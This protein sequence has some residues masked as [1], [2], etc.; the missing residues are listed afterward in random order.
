MQNWLLRPKV[1]WAVM[2]TMVLIGNGKCKDIQKR[3]DGKRE[4]DT[5]Q[6]ATDNNRISVEEGLFARKI[7]EAG[8]IHHYDRINIIVRIP[9]FI[10]TDE[11][12]M[13]LAD[14]MMAGS[15]MSDAFEGLKRQKEKFVAERVGVLKEYSMETEPTKGQKVK[16][17]KRKRSV[18]S[19]LGIIGGVAYSTFLGGL[20]EIQIRKLNTHLAET[21][22]EIKMIANK[23]NDLKKSQVIFEEKTVGVIKEVTESWLTMYDYMQCTTSLALAVLN[24][25]INFITYK[26]IVDNLLFPA[27]SGRNQVLLT[28]KILDITTLHQVVTKHPIFEN[29]EFGANPALLYSTSY[30]SLVGVNDQLTVA[31]L[32]LEF[33]VLKRN[34]YYPLFELK[35]V[36]LHIRDNQCTYFDIPENVIMM[37]EELR[38][39]DLQTCNRHNKL[40]LCPDHVLSYLPS[41]YQQTNYTCHQEQR[42]CDQSLEYVRT[43]TGVL[44]RTN[45]KEEVYYKDMEMKIRAIKTSR[46]DTAYI[47]WSKAE[48]VQ[49][50]NTTLF[51]PGVEVEEILITNYQTKLNFSETDLTMGEIAGTLNAVAKKYGTN[52]TELLK[53]SLSSKAGEKEVTIKG[54]LRTLYILVGLLYVAPIVML[55]K[56][57][58]TVSGRK[59]GGWGRYTRAN[60]NY[61]APR[62]VE[63]VTQG[64]GMIDNVLYDTISHSEIGARRCLSVT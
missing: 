24:G 1:L 64:P 27:L 29:S 8:I 30:L 26:S 3:Y 45:S 41:C 19:W 16:V 49:V 18:L 37:S 44:F 4:I 35:Q 15:Q 62:E 14:C 63:M 23:L 28:S 25:K 56:I 6:L 53:D 12:V 59:W 20:S 11:V 51:S 32:V 7:G 58:L 40:F 61:P 13:G 36:G 10:S 46:F 2:L 22:G 60:R 47:P 38:K 50:E 33:P 5:V 54:N 39:L 31:H 9:E 52:L 48:W 42:R 21:Q 55:I 57:I 17:G 43:D 34:S